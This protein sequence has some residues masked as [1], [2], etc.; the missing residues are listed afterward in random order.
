[1]PRQYTDDRASAGQAIRSITFTSDGKK[2]ISAGDDGRVI[3]WQLTPEGKR[4][5]EAVK[6]KEIAQRKHLINSI[7]INSQG[8]MVIIGGEECQKNQIGKKCIPQLIPL[9]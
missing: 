1:M 3:V 7:D 9:N 6:G 2:L 5:S 4:T 8:N